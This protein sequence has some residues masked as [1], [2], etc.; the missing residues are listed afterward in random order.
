MASS[1]GAADYLWSW[2]LELHAARG[3]NGFGA[4][5]IGWT[6]IDAWARQMRRKPAAWEVAAI[7]E[8]DR[9]Y[10]EEQARADGE[11]AKQRPG[12]ARGAH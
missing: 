9:V 12:A 4:G 2:F 7:R 8:L 3:S 10:L 5:P 6:D 1:P 11:R